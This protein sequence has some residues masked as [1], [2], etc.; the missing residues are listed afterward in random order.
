MSITIFIVDIYSRVTLFE[1]KEVFTMN[2]YFEPF[3]DIASLLI[4]STIVRQ[5]VFLLICI[6][7]DMME[8]YKN[9][10]GTILLS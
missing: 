5:R 2:S 4:W 7:I 8:H 9:I 3:I 6:A 1:D 10:L